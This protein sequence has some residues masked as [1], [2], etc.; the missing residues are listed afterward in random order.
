M[1]LCAYLTFRR[2]VRVLVPASSM[3]SISKSTCFG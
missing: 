2:T 3:Y 1:R